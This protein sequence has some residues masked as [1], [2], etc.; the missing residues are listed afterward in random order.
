MWHTIIHLRPP[1]DPCEANFETYVLLISQS[2]T[3]HAE[4]GVSE[5]LQKSILGRGVGKMSDNCIVRMGGEGGGNARGLG[6]RV[7]L[8]I[9]GKHGE[10]TSCC[11]SDIGIPWAVSRYNT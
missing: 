7:G 2:R 1:I 11:V 9:Q 3:F 10:L 4:R 5:I 6:V 8:T